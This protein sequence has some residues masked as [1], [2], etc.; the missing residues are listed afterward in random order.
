MSL[1][2]SLYLKIG[3]LVEAHSSARLVNRERGDRLFNAIE[4][5][6]PALQ[7]RRA[8]L[9]REWQSIGRW[10]VGKVHVSVKG[11]ATPELSTSVEADEARLVELNHWLERLEIALGA[12]FREF[13]NTTDELDKILED[14]NS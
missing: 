7:F 9:I 8:L 10:A 3:D 13:F 6:D 5:D 2:R 4:P 11:L 12:F 14:A 1:P